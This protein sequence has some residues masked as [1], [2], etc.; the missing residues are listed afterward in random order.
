MVFVALGGLAILY[1]LAGFGVFVEGIYPATMAFVASYFLS[2]GVL[3]GMSCLG[4]RAGSKR[5]LIIVL[6]MLSSISVTVGRVV[7][8]RKISASPVRNWELELRMVKLNAREKAD[9]INAKSKQET[10]D[11]RILEPAMRTDEKA[12][13]M[14]TGGTALLGIG[15]A[16]WRRK[17]REDE[18]IKP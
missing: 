3:F 11:V 15:S 5:I 17:R 8:A 14:I 4:R 12:G 13:W 7:A 18:V 16:V 2:V 6:I 1:S 9:I 10:E